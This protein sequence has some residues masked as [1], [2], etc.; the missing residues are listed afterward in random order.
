ME[1]LF[2][3]QSLFFTGNW[4]WRNNPGSSPSSTFRR[5]FPLVHNVSRNTSWR[6]S[7]H[8]HNTQRPVIPNAK[9]WGTT[10]RT[11]LPRGVRNPRHTYLTS[12]PFL[13]DMGLGS[14]PSSLHRRL[15]CSPLSYYQL[16]LSCRPFSRCTCDAAHIALCPL[17]TLHSDLFAYSLSH[18]AHEIWSGWIESVPSGIGPEPDTACHDYQHRCLQWNGSRPTIGKNQCTKVSFILRIVHCFIASLSLGW[19]A[20]PKELEPPGLKSRYC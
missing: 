10:P 20:S 2:S 13:V 15:D 8:I 19:S 1:S 5:G 18:R 14:K 6:C 17:A 12:F 3:P 11:Q 4:S 9:T 16:L 7:I